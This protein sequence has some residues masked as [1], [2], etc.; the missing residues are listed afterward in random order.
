MKCNIEKIAPCWLASGGDQPDT[1]RLITLTNGILDFDCYMAGDTTNMMLNH[2]PN[3]FTFYQLPYAFDENA[4][5]PLWESFC[6]ETFQNPDKILLASEWFGHQFEADMSHEVMMMFQGPPR[7]GKGTFAH[8][9]QAAL[10]GSPN[11]S[12]TTFPVLAGQFGL[13]PLHKALSVVIGDTTSGGGGNTERDILLT[14]L[15]IVGRDPAIIN[16]KHLRHLDMIRLRCRFTFCMNFFPK[17]RDDSGALLARTMILTFNNSYYGCED[18]TLKD[19]LAKEASEGKLLNWALRGLKSLHSR[20]AFIVPEESV[21]AKKVFASVVSP[22]GEFRE[23]TYGSD[24]TGQVP[25]SQIWWL[26]KEW[27]RDAG[28]KYGGKSDF[29]HKLLQTTPGT[30]EVP[31]GVGGNTERMIVGI[32]LTELATEA[33][34][35]C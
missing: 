24:P 31:R 14:I 18:K 28:G 20:G 33:L 32:K 25:A 12:V 6:E 17:F 5:S 29:I 4:E 27:C 2:D 35:T 3:L 26:W 10:G 21:K 11:A 34:G 7:G 13:A 30:K 8:A 1:R 22:F 15:N 23:D 16:Q 19:R 9:M